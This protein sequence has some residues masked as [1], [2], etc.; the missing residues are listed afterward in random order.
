MNEWKEVWYVWD[1]K[2]PI[3][4]YPTAVGLDSEGG[5]VS[6]TLGQKRRRCVECKG[7]GFRMFSG[8]S[9]GGIIMG[10]KA[11]CNTCNVTGWEYGK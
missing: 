4:S 9:S 7:K 2:S 10:H 8:I 1:K 5:V 3:A 11:K 6:Y